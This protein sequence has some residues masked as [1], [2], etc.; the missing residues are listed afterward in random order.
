M[1]LTV[2]YIANEFPAAVEWYVPAEIQEL[3]R[4]GVRVIP[5]SA[6]RSDP[7]LLAREQLELAKQTLYIEHFNV[8]IFFRMFRALPATLPRVA[9]LFVRVLCEGTEKPMRR[10]RGLLHT[11]L[12]LYF[13]ALLEGR[14]VEHIHVHHGYFSAWI[15]MV[16]ARAL[17]IPYSLTLHGSDLLLHAAYLDTKLAGCVFCLTISEFNRRYILAHYPVINPERVFVQRLGVEVPPTNLPVCGV[18]TDCR[19]PLLLSVGRLHPVKNH[20]F[21]VQACYVLREWGTDFRCTIAGEGLERR[22][23]EFLIEEF[24][25]QDVVTLAG[26]LSRPEVDAMYEQAD[27]VVL[28]SRSEGIPLVLMEA[29][30]REKLVLA[31][32]ITGIPELVIDGKTG[33]LYPPESLE[34]FV[35]RIDQI[36][37]SLNALDSVRRAARQCV[38]TH[39]DQQKNLAAFGKFFV[40]QL[41]K[42]ERRSIREDIVLQQI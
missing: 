24:R 7:A 17:G 23:L 5:C 40:E 13:A 22:K 1:P 4:R 28:T 18:K 21:L 19:K 16:A 14:D 6:R 31:P 2:A 34:Q 39:F 38:I 9:E 25:L 30:A 42:D 20:L 36:L 35:W 15:A 8:R 27:L 3:R 12:G 37:R 29:M 41:A 33:F 32:A 10:L 26:H 11:L